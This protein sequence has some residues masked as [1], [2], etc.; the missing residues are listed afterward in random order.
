MTNNKKYLYKGHALLSLLFFITIFSALLSAILTS[1][2]SISQFGKSIALRKKEDRLIKVSSLN[3]FPEKCSL[4]CNAQ[5]VCAGGRGTAED[6]EQGIIPIQF[7][8]LE[9]QSIQC[10]Q[11]SNPLT[12]R[13]S[14]FLCIEPHLQNSINIHGDGYF[15]E[16]LSEKAP[17]VIQTLG[18]IK[19]QC[20]KSDPT[21]IDFCLRS[22]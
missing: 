2:Q 1:N 4:T 18:G 17:L 3:N 8:E 12:F 13:I 14:Q 11:V 20:S 9:D 19:N 5:G 22:D 6:R 21:S 7:D 10:P 16:V 15:Q